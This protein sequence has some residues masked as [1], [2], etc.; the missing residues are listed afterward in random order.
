MCSKLG[1]MNLGDWNERQYFR[2]LARKLA[3]SHPGVLVS[4]PRDTN[5]F[6]EP[7]DAVPVEEFLGDK[8]GDD[9]D[10]IDEDDDTTG[11]EGGGSEQQHDDLVCTAAGAVPG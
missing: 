4:L 11:P 10:D 9:E 2:T 8:E 5:D 1:W 3:K 7:W 6:P